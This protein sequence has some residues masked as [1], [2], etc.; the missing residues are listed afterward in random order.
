MALFFGWDNYLGQSIT[1]ALPS[2]L[3]PGHSLLRN[4]LW[5]WTSGARV[6]NLGG[7][8][9]FTTGIP[10]STA[11]FDFYMV[12][13]NALSPKKINVPILPRIAAQSGAQELEEPQRILSSAS[14]CPRTS[15]VIGKVP[16]KVKSWCFQVT[17]WLWAGGI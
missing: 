12:F 4:V 6:S 16:Q 17:L 15:M 8:P 13:T 2:L 10:L 11:T 14:S 3:V 7:T 1:W 9:K 5:N